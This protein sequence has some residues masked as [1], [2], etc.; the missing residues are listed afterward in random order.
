MRRAGLGLVGLVLV[1]SAFI[2]GSNGYIYFTTRDRVFR[3]PEE[4][5]HRQTALVPGTSNKVV[6]G[7][8]NPFFIYRMDKAAQLY[9][10]G[11]VERFI[12]SGDNRTPFY[13]EPGMMLEALVNRGIP[14]E[15]IQLDTAGLRTLMSI[16]R[17]REVF[18]VESLTIVT[19]PFHA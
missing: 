12:L 15:I 17:S 19:Q 9:R 18:G 8:P 16:T 10:I 7:A 14:K 1:V 4:L 11:K 2:I 6:G 3:D 13:D 5:P